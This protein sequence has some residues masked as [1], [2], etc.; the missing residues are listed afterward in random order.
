MENRGK[1][2]PFDAVGESWGLGAFGAGG[3]ALFEAAI[4]GSL[5]LP[6]HPERR[7]LKL[8]SPIEARPSL[9]RRVM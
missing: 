4:H 1:S 9:G 5:R 8:G 6:K 3:R 7:G 2:D